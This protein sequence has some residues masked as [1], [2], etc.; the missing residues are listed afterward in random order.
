[1]LNIEKLIPHLQT[2]AIDSG[3]NLVSAILI[4]IIGWIVAGWAARWTRAGLNRVPQFDETLKPLL[5]STVRYLIVAITIIAVL[6]RFGVQTASLIAVMGAAGL[7][8]G[9]AMQGTLSNVAAGVMLLIL[10]PFRIGDYIDVSGTGG[11]VREIGLFTTTLATADLVYVSMP[12]ASIFNSVIV[13]YS[14][15]PVR[16][17][18]FTVGI[19]YE[20]DIDKAQQIA[21]DILNNDEKILKDPAPMV[22]VANLGESSVDL[23]IRC[24]VRN[25]DYWDRMFY[26][27]KAVKQ[28][29]DA[30]GISIPF[31]QR[32]VTMRQANGA[33]DAEKEAA[34]KAGGGAD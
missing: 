23:Y 25:S 10:R 34:A 1:M 17:I 7:A 14:R 32:V 12:N 8:V 11:T 21:L 29:F 26:L 15:E 16:R 18:N 24:W 3:L 9:L 4:L 20:D 33:S 30:A 2:I 31:P 13:N 6:Q 27:Q 22:P 28:A 19:D 5:V